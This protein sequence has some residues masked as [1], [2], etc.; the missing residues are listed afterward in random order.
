M[1]A[2]TE[3]IE[4]NFVGKLCP[5]EHVA[6]CGFGRVHFAGGRINAVVTERIDT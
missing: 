5:L 1:F 6:D 2:N 4:T 3:V